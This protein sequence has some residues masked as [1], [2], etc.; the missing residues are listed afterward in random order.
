MKIMKSILSITLLIFV[1]SAA[2]TA[3]SYNYEEME[4]QEY[5]ALLQEWQGRLDAAQQAITE[6]DASIEGANKCIED[7][8]AQI[9]ATWD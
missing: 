4:M 1:S 8:Q 2:L 3:Q 9:D 7:N 5:N 6:A